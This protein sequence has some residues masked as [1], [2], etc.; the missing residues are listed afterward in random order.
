MCLSWSLHLGQRGFLKQ[1][2]QGC[3]QQNNNVISHPRWQIVTNP[4]DWWKY[5]W[6]IPWKYHTCTKAPR[7]NPWTVRAPHTWT[8]LAVLCLVGRFNGW[9]SVVLM[10]ESFLLQCFI[11]C[12]F[13][14]F[15]LNSSSSSGVQY[16]RHI[17]SL[18]HCCFG[19]AG[20]GTPLVYW[21]F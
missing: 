11:W 9:E 20:A 2:S 15:Q 6:K 18:L 16:I 5:H 10:T 1:S 7:Q 8:G 13:M 3:W 19:P 4:C 21:P 14:T 17:R 12:Y